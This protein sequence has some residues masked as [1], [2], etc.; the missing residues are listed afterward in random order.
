M[1]FKEE[2]SIKNANQTIEREPSLSSFGFEPKYVDIRKPIP[3][4]NEPTKSS[5]LLKDP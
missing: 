3:I 4:D 2:N 1:R 5:N